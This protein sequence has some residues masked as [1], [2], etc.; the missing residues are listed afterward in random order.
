MAHFVPQD[1]W[2]ALMLA[3]DGGHTDIVQLLLSSAGAKIDL[4]NKVRHDINL[5]LVSKTGGIIFMKGACPPNFSVA[6]VTKWTQVLVCGIM[7][8]LTVA[9]ISILLPSNCLL[10]CDSANLSF[11]P[12]RMAILPSCWPVMVV[13]LMWYNC[14]FPVEP[15]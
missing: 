5:S 7:V 4:Q 13:T 11:C 12:I 14:F 10:P 6:S 15:K 1:G 9:C 3:S 2:A 8:L